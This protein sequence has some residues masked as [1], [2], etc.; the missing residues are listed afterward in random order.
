MGQ[1]IEAKFAVTNLDAFRARLLGLGGQVLIPRHLERN[2][3][4]DSPGGDFTSKGKVLRVRQGHEAFIT[5][6]ET[7]AD[8]LVRTELEFRVSDADEACQLLQA[9][10]FV[11]FSVYEKQREVVRWES[12]E[13]MLDELPL[14]P[15][16]EVEGDSVDAV[17]S[18]CDRLG[19]DW[20]RRI[21]E[22][23]LD[24]FQRCRNELE[25]AVENLTFEEFARL[26][27]FELA[28]LGLADGWTTGVPN[29][30]QG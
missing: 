2:W 25:L 6:K 28:R 19:L 13:V 18:A 9:L 29:G 4:F 22:S 7:G 5:Y 8:P 21:P 14:A 15:F 23:Y 1:E 27:T 24:I 10:G 3:R 26:G 11:P 20:Q 12:V 30:G 17:R 16:V